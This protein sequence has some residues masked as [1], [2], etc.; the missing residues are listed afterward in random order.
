[1]NKETSTRKYVIRRDGRI[2]DTCD[3][4]QQAR[5]WAS[6]WCEEIGGLWQVFEKYKK[7]DVEVYSIELK[8]K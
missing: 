3:N 8:D 6:S 1:M 4:L 5:Q 7:G 2:Y